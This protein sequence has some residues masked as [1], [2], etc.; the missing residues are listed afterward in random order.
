M[1][2]GL[3]NAILEDKFNKVFKDESWSICVRNF[4][5]LAWNDE[6]GNVIGKLAL[7]SARNADGSGRVELTTNE[8]EIL[9]STKTY[10]NELINF[11]YHNIVAFKCSSRMVS[12]ESQTT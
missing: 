2:V 9:I 1:E 12:Q 5:K 7:Q 8:K 4:M 11:S 6:H 3:P 10:K